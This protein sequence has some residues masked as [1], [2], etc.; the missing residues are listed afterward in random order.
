MQ[1]AQA[2][3]AQKSTSGFWGK[4]FAKKSKAQGTSRFWRKL[5]GKKSKTQHANGPLTETSHTSASRFPR[6]ELDKE[7]AGEDAYL[8]LDYCAKIFFPGRIFDFS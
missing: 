7:L 2:R 4:L 3:E 5:S 8:L 1:V 6:S